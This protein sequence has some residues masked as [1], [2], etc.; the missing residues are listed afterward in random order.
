MK[1]VIATLVCLAVLSLAGGCSASG[2]RSEPPCPR[3]SILSDGASLTKFRPGPG[4]DVTDVEMT[5]EVQGY[6]GYC[7]YNAKEKKMTVVLQVGVDVQRGPAAVGRTVEIPYF[8]ALPRFYPDPEA[9]RAMRIRVDFPDGLN[10]VRAI[11]DE[12]NISFSLSD[13]KELGA[14]E[15][16]VGLQLDEAQLEYSRASRR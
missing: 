9:K 1:P 16:F 2:G 12:M 14:Y 8:V 10:S 11:D 15:I 13:F 4:R 3:I 6:S 7:T 5:A